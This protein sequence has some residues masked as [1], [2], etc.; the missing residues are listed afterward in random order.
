MLILFKSLR[1][2]GTLKLTHKF[3]LEIKQLQSKV[4]DA[5][6]VT[7]FHLRRKENPRISIQRR[8]ASGVQEGRRWPQDPSPAIKPFQGL[9]GM[10]CHLQG[11]DGSGIAGPRDTLG[12]PW[13]PLDIRP[14][15]QEAGFYIRHQSLF[16]GFLSGLKALMSWSCSR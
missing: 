6:S 2:G 1:L 13:A 5:T 11:I 16:K 9:Q 4:H 12:T 10:L 15:I 8:T 14:C 3:S 7:K